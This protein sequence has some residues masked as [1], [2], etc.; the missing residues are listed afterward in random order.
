MAYVVAFNNDNSLKDITSR[1]CQN[2]N[3][4]TRKLRVNSTW[5][6][7]TIA[8]FLG[9][10]N[11]RDKE[12]DDEL[13]RQQLE[14][15]LPTAIAECKN[16]P[17]YVLSRHLLKFEAIYPPDAATLGFV[18]K[19]PVYSRSCVYTLHSRDIW[20]KHAKVVKLG[21][22]PYKIVK[23]RPKYD[24]VYLGENLNDLNFI[25]CF[26]L[27]VQFDDN[28]PTVGDFRTVASGRLCTSNR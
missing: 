5:W 21:E 1:Y 10:T 23:A 22:K 18:R 26:K 6:A 28:G 7:E 15:P 4:V 14:K 20:L 11:V 2:F 25:L 13:R 8:P 9:P 16:H 12:E 17:L 3:T 19:E 24:K 27:V